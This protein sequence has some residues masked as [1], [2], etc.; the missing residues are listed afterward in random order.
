M[1]SITLAGL[2]VHLALPLAPPRMFPN[3]GFVDTAR[4]FGPASYGA[5]SPYEGFANQF[6]A[7]P[8]L[9]FGWALVIAWAVIVAAGPHP[10]ALPGAAPPGHHPAGDRADREPLLARRGRGDVPVRARAGRRLQVIERWSRRN[11]AGRWARRCSWTCADR[12]ARGVGQADRHRLQRR[13]QALGDDHRLVRPGGHR[14][15]GDRARARG[16]ALDRSRCSR[17]RTTSCRAARAPPRWR[18]RRR[19]RPGPATRATAFTTI[20]SKSLKNATFG[21]K[22]SHSKNRVHAS[23]K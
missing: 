14:H 15:V 6:A 7:M 2:I 10:L 21:S 20:T 5:G 1:V 23:S 19:S 3:L 11:R 16:R 9:H 8:S 17:G 4:V 13:S 12:R 22:P 18:R